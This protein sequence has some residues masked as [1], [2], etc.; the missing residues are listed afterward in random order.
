MYVYLLVTVKEIVGSGWS[1]SRSQALLQLWS[2][3]SMQ[4]KQECFVIL[5]ARSK[6]KL[7]SVSPTEYMHKE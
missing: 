7:L 5:I 2:N 1:E 6:R 3:N 4:K